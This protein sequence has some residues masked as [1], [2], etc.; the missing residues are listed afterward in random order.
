MEGVLSSRRRVDRRLE[1]EVEGV[2]GAGE[3][4]LVAAW[5]RHSTDS[6]ICV[7]IYLAYPL[8]FSFP[9]AWIGRVLDDTER[10]DPEIA[11]RQ[12]SAN[13]NGVLH[14]RRHLEDRDRAQSLV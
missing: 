1:V 5:W 8:A 14:D 10:I 11:Y 4:A 7:L 9:V 13:R 6:K 12:G 2:L 3:E